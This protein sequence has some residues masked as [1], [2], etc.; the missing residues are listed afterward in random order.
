MRDESTITASGGQELCGNMSDTLL[1]QR[2]RQVWNQV[3]IMGNCYTTF[4]G[5]GALHL[6]FITGQY[7]GS[8]SKDLV[9]HGFRNVNHLNKYSDTS[10]KCGV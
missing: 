7:S 10:E 6:V 2:N 1:R 4:S 9:H 5:T 3:K 8:S